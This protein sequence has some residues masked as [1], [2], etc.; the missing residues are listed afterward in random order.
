MFAIWN[1]TACSVLVLI[2]LSNVTQS[3]YL[4]KDS[5]IQLDYSIPHRIICLS[6]VIQV[7]RICEPTIWAY[8][9]RSG[10]QNFKTFFT[11]T[12]SH[13]LCEKLGSM[14]HLRMFKKWMSFHYLKDSILYHIWTLSTKH[15]EFALVLLKES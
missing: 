7:L 12:H 13:W 8:H 2:M 6:N 1:M 15:S 9:L 14:Q 10:K 4:M 5:W 11:H 3:L